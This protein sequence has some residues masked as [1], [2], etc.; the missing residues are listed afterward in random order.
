MDYLESATKTVC[1]TTKLHTVS[2]CFDEIVNMCMDLALADSPYWKTYSAQRNAER[3]HFSV[4]TEISIIVTYIF[5]NFD[6]P[7]GLTECTKS[8]LKVQDKQGLH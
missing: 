8:K 3:E 2:K 5:L 7:L 6:S 1:V 4:F